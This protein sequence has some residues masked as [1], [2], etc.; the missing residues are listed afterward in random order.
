MQVKEVIE[1]ARVEKGWSTAEL[2]RRSGIKYQN[3]WA[4]LKGGRGIPAN[5][6]VELCR[7]LDLGVEDFTEQ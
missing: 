2:A 3:L 6:F 4:S 7:Q 1:Q 5:E